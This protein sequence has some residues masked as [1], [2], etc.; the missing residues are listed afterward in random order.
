[1]P[2]FKRSYASQLIRQISKLLTLTSCNFI[3]SDHSNCFFGWVP[4][5]GQTNQRN[6]NLGLFDSECNALFDYASLSFQ[7]FHKAHFSHL[8]VLT[9]SPLSDK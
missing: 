8:E 4:T 6:S 9:R 2:V 5:P 3:L 1:M 7:R